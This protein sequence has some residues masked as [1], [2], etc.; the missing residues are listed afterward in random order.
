[1]NNEVK[2]ILDNIRV[3]GETI[4]NALL[5]FDGVADT[6]VLYSPSGESVGLAGDDKPLEYIER[7]DIDVYSKSNYLALSKA[8]KQAFIDNDWVYLGRGVDTYDEPTKLYH[9]LLEFSKE[10]TGGNG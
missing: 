10:A 5:H 8:V 4:P 6:F 1:M 2:T 9:R 3:N 7:W